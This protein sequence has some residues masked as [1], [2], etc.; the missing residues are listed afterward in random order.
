MSTRKQGKVWLVGAGPG[1][2]EL[3]T[4]KAVR[5]IGS[6]DVI[7]I[8]DL[9]NQAVLQ[10]A[11]TDV[12]IVPVGK[13]GGCVSTPQ[14]FIE[15]LM[16]SEARMGKV[17]VRL[18]GGD[19]FMFGRGGEEIAALRAAG[20]EFEVINGITAGLAAPTLIGVP[21]THRDLCHGVA[22]VT[23]HAKDDEV[24]QWSSVLQVG[25]TLVIYMGVANL[26]KIATELQ[27]GGTSNAMPIAIIQNATL[28]TQRVLISTLDRVAEDSRAQAFASPSIV[29]IGAV[30]KLTD[31]A[32]IGRLTSVAATR[33]VSS[34][35]CLKQPYS[36]ALA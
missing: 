19:P 9:V 27:R 17:V 21:L 16:V 14:A 18:K 35:E 7:L 22:F 31:H 3:L 4:L 34:G 1:D 28:P 33:G 15:R 24:L 30:V 11:C 13:R 29:I 20:I 26:G 36:R 23:G 6:A 2:P 10:H 5:A 12:R 32:E 25:L 8:D